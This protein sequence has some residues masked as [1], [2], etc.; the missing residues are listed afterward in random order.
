[1]RWT[2]LDGLDQARPP[3]DAT[4]IFGILRLP[5]LNREPRYRSVVSLALRDFGHRPA[6]CKQPM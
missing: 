6:Y 1:M 5:S 4:S 2:G 3:F